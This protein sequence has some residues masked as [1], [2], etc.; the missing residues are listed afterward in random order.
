MYRPSVF[1][2]EL[3]DLAYPL[4]ILKEHSRQGLVYVAHVISGSVFIK[5]GCPVSVYYFGI[6]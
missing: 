3:L 5:P 2:Y 4:Q 1:F 6:I